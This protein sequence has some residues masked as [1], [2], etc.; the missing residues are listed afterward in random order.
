MPVNH[1][2][3]AAGRWIWGSPLVSRVKMNQ[4]VNPPVPALDSNG[5]KIDQWSFGVAYTKQDF[6]QHIWPAL[7]Y[8]AASIYPNGFPQ[9]FAWKFKDGDV[10]LDGNNKPLRDKEGYAG[11]MVLAVS[12]E[13]FAPKVVQLMQGIYQAISVGQTGLKCGDY[14]RLALNIVGHGKKPGTQSKPGLYLN[15]TLCE[16]IGVGKE[17]F[18]GPDAMQVLGGQAFTALPAGATPIGAAPQMGGNAGGFPGQNNG[19]FNPNGGQPQ[20]QQFN[21]NGGGGN[22]TQPPQQPNGGATN[23]GFNPNTGNPA[24]GFAG[25]AGQ[26]Q[27]NPAANGGQ[28]AFQTA[29]P[30]NAGPQGFNPNGG[31]AAPDYAFTGGGQPQQQQFNPNAG[32]QGFNPN[33]QQQTGP[34]GFNSNGGGQFPGV[35]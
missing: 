25:N 35:R 4:N 28:T 26:F 29:S 23:P 18:Q 30:S 3:Q 24:G 8:E 15:P 31:G 16:W 11:H 10:D 6:A 21:P 5:N 20:Q 22:F 2:I 33:G 12:T 7:Q 19:G 17:I 13:A 14:F 1:T 32:P 9:D 27:G 34:Q